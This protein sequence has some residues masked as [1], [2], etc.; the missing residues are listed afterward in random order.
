MKFIRSEL[1]EGMV[2]HAR[3]QTTFGKLI[4]KCLPKAWGNHDGIFIYMY[5]QWWVGESVPMDARLTP[6]ETYESWVTAGEC[7]VRVYDIVSASPLDRELAVE[8][9]VTHILGT[10]YDF[11]AFPRLILKAIFGSI[12][13]KEVGWEWAHWCTEGD[14]FAW[15]KGTK[16]TVWGKA[17]PTPYTTEKRLG[18]TLRDVSSITMEVKETNKLTK[19]NK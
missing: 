13:N 3:T 1:K 19:E 7:E 6:I 17:N 14:A 9:W 8:Y 10:L 16:L 18:S 2:L 12:S 11:L 5:D 15:D 4:R